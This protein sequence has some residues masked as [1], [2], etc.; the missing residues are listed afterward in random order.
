MTSERP[1]T[2]VAIIRA[3]K[4]VPADIDDDLWTAIGDPTRF[5]VLDFLVVAG[6]GTASSIARKLPV[7]RQ[8]VAKHLT[9]LERSG[10]IHS[11]T[12]GREVKYE[13]D[14]AQFARANAQ[15]NRV[16]RAWDDRLLQIKTLAE[17][18]K[19]SSVQAVQSER[20]PDAAPAI[21]EISASTHKPGSTRQ[22]K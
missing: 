18:M 16:S 15:L 10:L 21:N 4:Q 19:G 13:V 20:T 1:T 14:A 8:A 9:I 6:S 3:E 11:E 2:P 22:G 17:S 7:T 12:A 5:R